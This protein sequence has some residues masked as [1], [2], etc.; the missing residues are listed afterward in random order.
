[1][2]EAGFGAATRAKVFG[3]AGMLASQSTYRSEAI[4]LIALPEM[5]GKAWSDQSNGNEVWAIVRNRRLVTVMLRR[6][7][8]PKTAAAFDVERVTRIG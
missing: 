6:S 7:T 2:S 3:A 1:M 5:V 4:R 8:Q